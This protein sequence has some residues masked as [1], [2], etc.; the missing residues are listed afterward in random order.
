M[1]ITRFYPSLDHSSPSMTEDELGDYVS[2]E[3]YREEVERLEA[4]IAELCDRES[5]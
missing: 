2:Y 1:P 4:I 5:E 3:D